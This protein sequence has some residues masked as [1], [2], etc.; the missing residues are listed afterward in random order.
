MIKRYQFRL[1]PVHK[2]RKL[3]EEN[4]RTELGQMIIEL[5]RIL[6]QLEHDRKEI[7]KY[8]QIQEGSLKQGM[9]GGRLQAFPML[10][11]GKE[12]NIQL[13]LGY[14]L[15]QEKAIEIKRQELAVLRGELKVIENLKEKDF[16]EWRKAVNKEIDQKVE[17]QTQI[18]SHHQDQDKKGLI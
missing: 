6:A 17:E 4:C 14:K 12:R 9:L 7:D 18:W 16:Q 2:L 8:Y 1:E 10:V 3:K 15:R 5:D 13:L 11:Q